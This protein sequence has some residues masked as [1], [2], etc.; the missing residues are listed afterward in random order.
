MQEKFSAVEVES[1]RTDLLNGGLDLFQVAD[2]IKVFVAMRGYGISV[3]V[4]REIASKIEDT[5]DST[6]FFRKGLESM[7]LVM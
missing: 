2:A 7:V 6:D 1:L 4:A 5:S 3:E